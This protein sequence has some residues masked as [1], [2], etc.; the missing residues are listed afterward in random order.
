MIALLG[1]PIILLGLLF[2]LFIL[3][4]G[5]LSFFP[6]LILIAMC[7]VGFGGLLNSKGHIHVREHVLDML[8][9]AV[10][11]LAIALLIN[12]AR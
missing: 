8:P 10:L 1:V 12:V 7:A 3:M 11:V 2:P 5:V 4:T 9:G 6:N